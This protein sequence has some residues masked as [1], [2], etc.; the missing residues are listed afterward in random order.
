VWKTI[1]VVTCVQVSAEHF[2]VARAF[3]SETQAR[4]YAVSQTYSASRRRPW[5]T[6]PHFR[7]D[8]VM[9]DESEPT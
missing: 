1:Y 8:A 3:A 4:E 2:Y 7:V 6:P 9:F 5:S